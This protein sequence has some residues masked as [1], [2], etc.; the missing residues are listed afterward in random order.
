[1]TLDEA[2]EWCSRE[3]TEKIRYV[4]GEKII[5]WFDGFRRQ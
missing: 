2:R 5:D 3:D 1:M 4:R